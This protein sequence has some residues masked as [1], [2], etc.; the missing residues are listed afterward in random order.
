[1]IFKPNM[2]VVLTNGRLAGK[3]AVVVKELDEQNVLVAGVARTPVASEDFTPAWLKRRNAKFM[4]F[5]K[6]VN[7]NHVLATRYKADIGLAGLKVNSA[8]E[9]LEAKK[10][11]NS[12]AN[13]LMKNAYE[14]SKSKWLFTPLKF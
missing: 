12:E 7:I 10:S 11:A 13:T 6:K 4:T 3:K 9:D 2:I 14:A 1:M 8:V 5:I